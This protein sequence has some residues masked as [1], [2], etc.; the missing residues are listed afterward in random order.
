MTT[1][2]IDVGPLL[3][4]L[5]HLVEYYCVFA[6]G[7][8]TTLKYAVSPSEIFMLLFIGQFLACLKAIVVPVYF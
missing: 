1:Y 3:P 7:L 8:V 4:S 5:E 6:D 2:F